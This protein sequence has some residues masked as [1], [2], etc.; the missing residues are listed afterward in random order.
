MGKFTQQ[1]RTSCSTRSRARA[2]AAP[3]THAGL[4]DQATAIT[5]VTGEADDDTFT[6]T[7]HGL[8]NGD[9]VILTAVTGGGGAFMVGN[10]DNGDENAEFA[11]RD[12]RDRKHLPAHPGRAAAAPSL[13]ARTLRRRPLSSSSKSRAARR[14]TRGRRS[15]S[16]TRST[17][18]WTTRRTAPSSTCPPAPRSTTSATGRPARPGPCRPSTR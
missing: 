9:V 16:I 17:A 8:S 7:A 1:A 10:A 11:F 3:I 18:A 5:G 6:K 12:R 15:P 13:S 14:R 4:F 2:P